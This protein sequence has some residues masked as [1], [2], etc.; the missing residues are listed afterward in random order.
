MANRKLPLAL[1]RITGAD[2]KNPSRYRGSSE[3]SSSGGVGDPPAHLSASAKRAWRSFRNE[4]PWLQ[5]SDRFILASASLLRA[6]FEDQDELPSAAFIREYRATLSVIGA[7][8]VD[9]QRLGWSPPDDEDHPL[10]KFF[11]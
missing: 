1:A 3:P 8:P 2:R 6:R 4:L 11:Q 7:T 9:R 5:R 10:E